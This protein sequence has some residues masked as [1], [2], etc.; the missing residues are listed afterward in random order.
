MTGDRVRRQKA[1]EVDVEVHG[2]VWLVGH[3]ASPALVGSIELCT[4]LDRRPAS[5]RRLPAR[6]LGRLR[7]E[8]G[9]RASAS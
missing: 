2:T 7:R 1:D 9:C 8:L 4:W 5:D 3:L 6:E